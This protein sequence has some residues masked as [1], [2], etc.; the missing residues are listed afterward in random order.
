MPCRTTSSG[1]LRR[2]G[3]ALSRATDS[4]ARPRAADLHREAALRLG[5]ADQR[6]TGK[7]RSLVEVLAG[8]DRPLSMQEI[9]AA[10]RD[11]PQSSAYRNL[12]VLA[13]AGVV[14]RVQGADDNG[15]YELAENLSGHHHHHLICTSCGS[16]ADVTASAKLERALDEAARAAAEEATF[17]VVEHRFDL[18]GL[19]ARCH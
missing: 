10:D 4:D 12:A 6:Y 18:V 16:V 9:M 3:A 17:A 14:R 11:I 15:R 2:S 1:V 8:S 7:R 13:E 5:A 19:C